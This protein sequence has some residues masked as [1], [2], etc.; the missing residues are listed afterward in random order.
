[1]AVHHSDIRVETH[2]NYLPAG[3][4]MVLG[5]TAAGAPLGSILDSVAEL[6]E[7]DLTDCHCS[8]MLLDEHGVLGV[9]SA[10]SLP[11]S[12][13]SAL[14][15]GLA[16]RVGEGSFGEAVRTGRPVVTEDVMTA[17]SWR[18]YRDAAARHG[19]RACWSIP[20]L[21]ERQTPLGAFALYYD[22]PR[23]PA[24]A[25]IQLLSGYAQLVS[26]AV[27]RDT[28][29]RALDRAV[30]FDPVT[31]LPDRRHL[32]A[33]LEEAVLRW[34]RQAGGW[35]A[36]AMVE[37][38]RLRECNE[39]FGYQGG[40]E[41]VVQT[42]NRLRA[43]LED[44][45]HLFRTGGSSFTVVLKGH[46]DAETTA[47]GQRMVD[48]L[49]AP[50]TVSNVAFS[51]NPAVGI[52]VA[53]E[54]TSTS[55]ALMQGA[56]A[57]LSRAR[58]TT[59]PTAVTANP[60]DNRTTAKRLHLESDLRRGLDSGELV[61]HYQPQYDLRQNAVVGVEALVR[62][63]HPHRGLLP[64]GAFLDV[65]TRAGLHA[66]LRE[67]AL[68]QACR[69]AA[70]WHLAFPDAA[71]PVAVNLTPQD[72]HDPTLPRVVD[73]SLRAHGLPGHLLCLEVT[74]QA[75]LID[76]EAA[77]AALATLNELDVQVAM[78]DFG[79]GY[80]SLAY[81]GSLPVSYLKVD[82]SF[83]CDITTNPR[84]VAVVSAITA[85]AEGLG[86]HVLA[87]GIETHEQRRAVLDLG[88][89][90]GQGY[91]WSPAVPVAEI[92]DILRRRRPPN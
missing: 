11:H 86:I 33:V 56:Q 68:R 87:E 2:G 16:A 46:G 20:I 88:C 53:T 31:G 59:G 52:A 85:L 29:V 7:L 4:A 23:P 75:A 90:S 26:V 39:A 15:R 50:L 14:E 32:Q 37:M 82:R 42:A 58:T 30:R 44:S 35:L 49:A 81:A 21:G 76:I 62:W 41:L 73:R 24:S 92:S 1:M 47:Q 80:S 6:I 27:Q 19:L 12:Y 43:L 13:I 51:P 84:H 38:R 36:V 66:T 45:S 69:D 8:V 57:A 63:Q 89:Q 60:L 22:T 61:V 54:T 77:Q 83:V 91:L 9:A 64:P 70:V 10:P 48:A 28:T 71:L 55:A 79:T 65:I 18:A 34:Q 67:T 40:D 72:L 74:E 17:A 78:D 3:H 25:D 5:M